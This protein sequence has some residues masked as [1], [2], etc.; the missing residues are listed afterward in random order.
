MDRTCSTCNCPDLKFIGRAIPYPVSCAY[1]ALGGLLLVIAYV[2]SRPRIYRCA[3]HVVRER[4]VGTTTIVVLTSATGFSPSSRRRHL[5]SSL[6]LEL[7]K[8]SLDSEYSSYF[9]GANAPNHPR[10]GERTTK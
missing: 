8:S 2:E 9:L 5:F 4:K 3:L 10:F 6:S 7:P 1:L